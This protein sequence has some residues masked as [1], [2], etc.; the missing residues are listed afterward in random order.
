MKKYTWKLHN[1]IQ[2]CS[3]ARVHRSKKKKAGKCLVTENAEK[4]HVL[5][6]TSVQKNQQFAQAWPAQEV[7]DKYCFPSN[8]GIEG[9]CH[10]VS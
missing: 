1:T 10:S 3:T 5:F 8:V 7:Q 2:V 6:K 4:K 9:S